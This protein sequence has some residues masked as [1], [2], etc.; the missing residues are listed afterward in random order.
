VL[1]LVI[2]IHHYSLDTCG[3]CSNSHYLGHIKNVYD[4]DDGD[5]DIACVLT[6]VNK[7]IYCCTVYLCNVHFSQFPV[8]SLPCAMTGR[9]IIVT[10]GSSGIG[11]EVCKYLA[12]GGNDVILACR[13]REK[14]DEAVRRIKQLYP[15][16]LIQFM[17]VSHASLPTCYRI[18]KPTR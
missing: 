9:V 10:G 6:S 2:T 7:R 14:G 17:Q 5:N 1:L 15:N 18:R 8:A 3:P 11:F 12:E 4:I 16:A 13:S